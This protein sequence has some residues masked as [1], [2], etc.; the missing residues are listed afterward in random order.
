MHEFTQ[1]IAVRSGL[2]GDTRWWL[3]IGTGINKFD[4]RAANDS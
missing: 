4:H 1:L 2:A 3:G